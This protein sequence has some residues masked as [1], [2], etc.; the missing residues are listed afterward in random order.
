[1]RPAL[2]LI[3]SFLFLCPLGTAQAE[4]RTSAEWKELFSELKGALYSKFKRKRIKAIRRLGEANY[5]KAVQT[6]VTL[7]EKDNPRLA[8]LEVRV[9]EIL[10]EIQRLSKLARNQ[11]NRLAPSDINK[12]K[13]MQ[14]ELREINMAALREGDMRELA[15]ECLTRT[16]DEE[17]IKWL[18]G[19]WKKS[20]A[21]RAPLAILKAFGFMHFPGVTEELRQGTVHRDP[22][23]RV[24]ALWSLGIHGPLA[25]WKTMR[26]ALLD[27]F[28]QVRA[29]A[30]DWLRSELRTCFPL[31]RPLAALVR[32]EIARAIGLPTVGR[33][34]EMM[35]A[36]TGRLRGDIDALLLVLV[37]RS[38]SG[39]HELWKSWW[40]VH[41]SDVLAGKSV[42]PHDGK[43]AG[44]LRT[45]SFYGIQSL[46]KNIL[47]IVDV[48]GSMN[49][50]SPVAEKADKDGATPQAGPE[51]DKKISIA[52][53]ELKK[54]IGLLDDGARFNIIY[55]N[56]KVMLFSSK[57]VKTTK[58]SRKKVLRFID[59]MRAEG[60][61]NIYDALV[62]A[63]NLGGGEGKE[64][65]NFSQS[66]DTIFFLSDG[67]P[68]VG[69]L[70]D[71]ELILKD[72]R[73]RNRLRK[74]IIHAIGLSTKT[75]KPE[76]ESKLEEFVKKLA[77]QNGGK[78]VKR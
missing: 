55:Y 44:A 42:D 7:I 2:L 51:D 35:G 6:L 45:V 17:S 9:R 56:S 52:K 36:E 3:L 66:V 43:G 10:K 20:S 30:V 27:D 70:T 38:F 25:A 65:K 8:I 33:F 77:E 48:S 71:I 47:F 69:K 31:G 60:G 37:G 19:R 75:D 14:A 34:I 23:L 16:T 57:M 53:W 26:E 4:I 41:G 73:K 29:T 22:Q 67:V 74:I 76:E 78:Y 40:A 72:I 5:I 18:R 32:R 68:S 12:I 59:G 11:G 24:Q 15:T 28:W 21:N 46:S 63:F 1:M 13:V 61:T 64:K 54:A 50:K 62:K 58:A 49:W 39:D